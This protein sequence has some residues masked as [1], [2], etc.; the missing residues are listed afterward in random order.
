MAL[1][2]SSIYPTFGP[3]NSWVYVNGTDLT[4]VTRIMCVNAGDARDEVRP[5]TVEIYGN[6]QLGFAIPASVAGYRSFNVKLESGEEEYQFEDPFTIGVP[7]EAPVITEVNMYPTQ[8]PAINWVYVWGSDFYF[9][10]TSVSYG[11]SGEIAAYVYAPDQCGFAKRN[12]E[13]E[14]ASITLRT[15]N[16]TVT[17]TL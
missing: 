2:I 9:G 13:D 10:E 1:T 3:V 8:E 7:E 14:M 15:P 16:G 17:Y 6:G 12:I 4:T 5:D 11:E